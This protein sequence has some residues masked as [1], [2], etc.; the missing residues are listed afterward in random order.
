MTQLSIGD[1]EFWRRLAKAFEM[2]GQGD[3]ILIRYRPIG[4]GDVASNPAGASITLLASFTG[5]I[6]DENYWVYRLRK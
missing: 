1:A 6:T 3:V 2:A 5:A 4:P